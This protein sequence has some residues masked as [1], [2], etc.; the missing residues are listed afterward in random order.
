[1]SSRKT[2]LSVFAADGGHV[3][4][5]EERRPRVGAT[6]DQKQSLSGPEF[7]VREGELIVPFI[8]GL[9]GRQGDRG[10]PCS[11]AP[12]SA[13]KRASSRLRMSTAGTEQR[14]VLVTV[15]LC[16]SVG[17]EG[18]TLDRRRSVDVIA[19]GYQRFNRTGAQPSTG[20]QGQARP[21]LD[22]GEESRWSRSRAARW[23]NAW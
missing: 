2:A 14:Q 22:G 13:Q 15:G 8:F 17:V 19:G 5:E 9:D 10:V 12:H 11:G 18:T 20:H 6:L 7:I 3:V 23:T 16:T 21:S 1:M 4:L